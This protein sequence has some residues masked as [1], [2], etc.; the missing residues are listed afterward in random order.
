[1]TKRDTGKFQERLIHIMEKL[2]TGIN[3]AEVGVDK[4]DEALCQRIVSAP[5]IEETVEEFQVA[6]DEACKAS[7]RLTR[8]TSTSKKATQHKSVPW[9]AQNL[10]IL[11]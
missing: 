11:R 8:P 4:L 1:M 7:F 3:T 5:N 10:T 6:P 9:W 2:L